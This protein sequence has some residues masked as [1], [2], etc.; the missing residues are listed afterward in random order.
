MLELGD[1]T[2][3]DGRVAKSF[4][5]ALGVRHVSVDLGGLNGSL[6]LDLRD[7][8]TDAHPEWEDYFDV[9]TDF[10]TT[11]HV[12][13]SFYLPWRNMHA[14]CRM[15]GLVV[16]ALPEIESWVGHGHSYVTTATFEVLQSLGPYQIVQLDRE[17]Y[18]GNQNSVL[19]RAVMRKTG[20][21]PSKETFDTLVPIY[22]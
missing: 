19:V 6:P 9:V 1:Q 4:L 11:E 21:F 13:E 17:I 15:D 16:H 3:S 10:G 7:T 12:G 8:L 5:E 18:L 22:K 20:R 14:C 2:F